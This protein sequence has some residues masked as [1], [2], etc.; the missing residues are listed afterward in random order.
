MLRET[1]SDAAHGRVA[2]VTGAAS[3]IGRATVA[4]LLLDGWR[5]AAG[6]LDQSLLKEQLSEA[7]DAALPLHLDIANAVAVEAFFEEAWRRFGQLDALANIAGVT[8]VSDVEIENVSPDLFEQVIAINLTG[9]FRMCRA[10]IPRLRAS[11]GGGIVNLGSV[12]SLRGGGGTAYVSSKAGIAGLTRAIAVHYA[13]ENIRCNTV[14]P[15]RTRTPMLDRAE[16]KASIR[17]AVGTL[18]PEAQP[19]EIAALIAFLLRPE[20]RY[21][22]G[23][24]YAID[25][26]ATQH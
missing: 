14:A 3:G 7:G 4:R 10:A 21:I 12:A 6:D 15:G 8:H 22:T 2:V 16:Q 17:P 1:L 24:L 19:H 9:T 13:S 23:A 26:G 25:G 11:G 20:A 18:V 5:V